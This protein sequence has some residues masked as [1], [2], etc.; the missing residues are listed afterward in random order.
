MIPD[1]KLTIESR[2]LT[3]VIQSRMEELLEGVVFL[4]Q[5]WNFEKGEDEILLTGGGSRLLDVDALLQR[6]SGHRVGRACV[7]RVQSSK[8]EV[9]R[10]PE[11]MVALGLLLC[12]HEEPQETK[13]GLLDKLKGL[14]G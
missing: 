8:E 2:D 4:L 10:T 9:L 5:G 14:F 6:L 7:K 11:Y 12:S 3:T 13:T 1:T